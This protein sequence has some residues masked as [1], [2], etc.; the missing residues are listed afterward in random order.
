MVLHNGNLW[1]MQQDFSEWRRDDK[2]QTVETVKEHR[3]YNFELV[4]DWWFWSLNSHQTPNCLVHLF[5]F[6][7]IR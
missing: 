5:S 1:N 2:A 4:Q 6:F 3:N 7:S